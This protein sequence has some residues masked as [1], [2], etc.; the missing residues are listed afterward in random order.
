MEHRLELAPLTHQLH[1]DGRISDQDLARIAQNARVK[2]HPL[3]YLAEQRLADLSCPGK[4]LDMEGLLAWLST[5]TE[6][7]VYEI[8]PLKIN[9]TEVAEVMSQA[10]AERH[11]I[12][13]V[14]V[15][16]D[17]V[18]I[19]TAEPYINGW[20]GNLEH[21]LRKR[22]RRVLADP[23]DIARHTAEFYSMA[24]SVRGARGSDRLEVKPGTSNLEQMLELGSMKEPDAN[25]QH[26]VN[27][28]DWL[29]QYAF[30][31]RASDIHIEPR[32]DVGNVRFRIDGVLHSV[33]EL[34][35]Q[36]GA[37]VTSRIKILGRM[38]VAEKRRPQDGRLKTRTP[39]GNE[40]ELRLATLPTAFGEKLVM[41]IFDPDVL[42]KSFEQL[43]LTEDDL[44]RWHQMTSVGNG[45]V[46][47]TGPTGS[48]KTT[49]LYS[50]LRQLATSEVNVCT[51]ED[52]I[53]MMEP[54]FN[55]MQVNHGISL[56]FASG[57]RALMRQD[58]DIIMIGEIRDLETANMAVQA[59]LTGHLVLS[60]LHTNDSPSSLSRLLELGV[61]AYLIKAT[62]RGVMSQRLVR[63][64]CSHC[65]TSEPLDHDA[66]HQLTSPWQMQP[67]EQ[68][69]RP[70]GCRICRDTGYM[71][72]QGIYEVLVN[73]PAVQGEIHPQLETT[74]IRKIAMREGMKTLRLSGASRVA[75]GQTTIEEVMRVAPVLDA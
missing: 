33:Y 35:Q 24:G 59:A 62:V 11:R 13:A 14:E 53:E 23:R 69:A 74:T 36:V 2:V 47:V 31:Q 50:T 45:I 4:V 49:T 27:I 61:P 34:P 12:L 63:M 57:V 29:L 28:V 44:L 17:E 32:R 67:P 40:V 70:V 46:L 65:K 5:R 19:A 48:G 38:D 55:Q 75:R 43:G 15:H 20:E 22:I 10:F 25:D 66:W 26:I 39:E 68:V 7:A 54:A 30:E 60:T 37:A 41:R 9:V 8:D 73:S 58:P 56:D 51:I 16:T 3:I 72:R 6:Q 21:V 52:P 64:L 1:S 71:G 42:Q 18:W